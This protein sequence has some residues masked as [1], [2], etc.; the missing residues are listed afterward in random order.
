MLV[1]TGNISGLKE[2]EEKLKRL[3]L[4][5][6]RTAVTEAATTALE[7]TLD[8]AR[9]NA[10][11]L[12]GLLRSEIALKPL[13]DSRYPGATV[14]V[15]DEAYSGDAFYG[16]FIEFGHHWGKRQRIKRPPKGTKIQHHAQI[17]KLLKAVNEARPW[18][19]P[20]PFLRRAFDETAEEVGRVFATEIGREIER[21]GT[22]KS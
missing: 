18:V 7:I 3:P 19:P 6:Q 14:E 15:G 21:I 13:P 20:N 8:A 5:V 2:L 10:P 17:A 12:T 16:S 4:E 9:A 11:V 1:V 22:A